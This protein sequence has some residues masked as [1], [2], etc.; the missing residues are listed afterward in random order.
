[1]SGIGNKCQKE[2]AGVQPVLPNMVKVLESEK[3]ITTRKITEAITEIKREAL[4]SSDFRRLLR[5]G[6]LISLYSVVVSQSLRLFRKGEAE[7]FLS[8]SPPQGASALF[9]LIVRYMFN[10]LY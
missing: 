9:L 3:R 10:I 8:P 7:I 2:T 6:S 1:M 5:K 4:L